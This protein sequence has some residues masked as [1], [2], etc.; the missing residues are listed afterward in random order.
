M[1]RIEGTDGLVALEQA[2]TQGGHIDIIVGRPDRQIGLGAVVGLPHAIL[3]GGDFKRV[4]RVFRDRAGRIVDPYRA[5]RALLREQG[6]I[7][8]PVLKA[9]V[10]GQIH[11]LKIGID[12]RVRRDVDGAVEVEGHIGQRASGEG[13][14]ADVLHAAAQIQLLTPGI[15]KGTIADG[16]QR[17][18][19]LQHGG[20]NVP[21]GPAADLLQ[22][23][24]PPDVEEIRVAKRFLPDDPQ[25][26]REGGPG[27]IAGLTEGCSLNALQPL[28]EHDAVDAVVVP[29]G[30]RA[31]GLHRHAADGRGNLHEGVVL[32]V[33]GDGA[34]GSI[35]IKPALGVGNPGIDGILAAG[36]QAIRRCVDIRQRVGIGAQL[37]VGH[38]DHAVVRQPSKAPIG[39]QKD[40]A[41]ALEGDRLQAFAGV[42][43]A[44][45]DAHAGRN[46]QAGQRAAVVEGGADVL[47][48][49]VQLHAGQAVHPRNGPLLNRPQRVGHRQR[50]DLMV[51][52]EDAVLK[53]VD[54]IPVHLGGDRHVTAHAAFQLQ[55]HVSAV[56]R[57]Q[58]FLRQPR[59]RQGQQQH[60]QQRRQPFS[61]F[62]RRCL[63]S[64]RSDRAALIPARTSDRP[65]RLHRDPRPPKGPL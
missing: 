24:A 44:V 34:G 20:P 8:V 43:R 39:V 17:A 35:E 31:D 52:I 62:H 60:R 36:L 33:G 48:A 27:Q 19:Q 11:I 15:L 49:V 42:D 63:L 3:N 55:A 59:Q 32:P 1:M 46:R 2:V 65:H 25:R 18:R 7:G 61:A 54:R 13:A 58:L 23:F 37:I 47:Q 14:G 5:V 9:A 16:A 6:G 51:G 26:G 40:R 38:I 53:G 28:R 64:I 50:G 41:N 21:E 22:P 57:P 12:E 30:L 56:V 10:P 29:E 45:H 4:G